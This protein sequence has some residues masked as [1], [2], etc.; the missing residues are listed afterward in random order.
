[1]Y[2]AGNENDIRDSLCCYKAFLSSSKHSVHF[3]HCLYSCWNTRDASRIWFQGAEAGGPARDEG[4]EA[5][6]LH[7]GCKGAA[8][9]GVAGSGESRAHRCR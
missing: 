9:L 2:A 4:L 5:F 3:G 8:S 1:M 7:G 6:G